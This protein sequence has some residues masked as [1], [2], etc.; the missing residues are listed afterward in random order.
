MKTHLHNISLAAMAAALILPASAAA[1]QVQGEPVLE[2][3]SAPRVGHVEVMPYI[4]AAQVFTTQLEPIND[5]VT[6]TSVAAGVDASVQGRNSA[7]SASV[8]YERRFG[9]DSGFSDSDTVSGIARASI[10][11]LGEPR[12]TDARAIPLTVSLSENPL[13]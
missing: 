4:E 6:Y 2:S 10:V 5:S 3:G 12:P 13:S 7:G 8:R 9:Y 11:T 1:Q